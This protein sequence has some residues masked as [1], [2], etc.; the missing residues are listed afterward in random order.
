[1]PAMLSRWV[2]RLM[3]AARVLLGTLLLASIAL[4]FANVVARYLF[5]A[6]IIW[7]EEIM[8][9]ILLWSVFLGAALVTWNDEHLRM[10]ILS[11]R[12]PPRWQEALHVASGLCMVGILLFI[13]VQ[14]IRIV[15]LFI[16]YGQKAA[17]TELPIAIPH[18]AIP[19]G[20]ALMLLAIAARR[21]R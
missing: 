6:P 13:L 7:A 18:L 9:F 17:V 1:M 3:Q 21:R 11:D 8:T 5:R 14:S 10:N 2:E 12:L 4:N 19:A 20:F 16:G 15:S